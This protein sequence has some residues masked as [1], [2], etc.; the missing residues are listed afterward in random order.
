MSRCSVHEREGDLLR[1]LAEF[2]RIVAYGG[3]LAVLPHRIRSLSGRAG[4]HLSPLL[5]RLP[6]PAAWATRKSPGRSTSARLLLVEAT[7]DRHCQWSWRCSASARRSGCDPGMTTILLELDPLVWP[8]SA[9][10]STPTTACFAN[11]RPCGST[12]SRP[13]SRPP[14]PRPGRERTS[15]R[16]VREYRDQPSGPTPPSCYAGKAFLCRAIAR[17]VQ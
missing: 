7:R 11:R 6:G 4:G 5:R 17:W 3:F 10:F 16:V 1:A 13:N 14:A 12:R 2:P 15:G 8:R 9:R